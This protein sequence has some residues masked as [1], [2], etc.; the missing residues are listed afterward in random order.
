[1]LPLALGSKA[2]SY[3]EAAGRML[4][5]PWASPDLGQEGAYTA[6]DRHPADR[7]QLQV[8][9][10]L[11]TD[12]VAAGHEDYRYGSIQAHLACP[13]LLQPSQL[14]LH[15]PSSWGLKNSP[16]P[17]GPRRRIPQR[18]ELAFTEAHPLIPHV[19]SHSLRERGWPIHLMW[20][21]AIPGSLASSGWVSLLDVSNS[22]PP[23]AGAVDS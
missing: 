19:L 22:G 10:T 21:L 15:I 18:V 16:A 14:F 17:S 5:I 2:L 4:G 20:V 11:S 23:R 7:A 8:G 13:L 12:Q 9:G 3:I 6:T 1:M